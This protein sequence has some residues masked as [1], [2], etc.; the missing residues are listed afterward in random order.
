MTVSMGYHH[1]CVFCGFSRQAASRTILSPRCERC[2][3]V[4]EAVETDGIAA[5][6][7]PVVYAG[8]SGWGHRAASSAWAAFCLAVVALTCAATWAATGPALGV[9]ALG[10]GILALAPLTGPPTRR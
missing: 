10:G 6:P 5:S 4:L 7:A 2:G 3:A 8:G 1:R 9:A